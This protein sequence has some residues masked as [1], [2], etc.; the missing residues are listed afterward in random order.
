[1]KIYSMNRVSIYEQHQHLLIQ[2]MLQYDIIYYL[3]EVSLNW[4]QV[5]N[6]IFYV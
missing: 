1:M 5:V 2:E 6:P 4:E 3:Y